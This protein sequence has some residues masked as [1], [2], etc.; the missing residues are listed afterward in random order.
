MTKPKHGIEVPLSSLSFE[1]LDEVEDKL[2]SNMPLDP[3]AALETIEEAAELFDYEIVVE[4]RALH[5]AGVRITLT[6]ASQ[7]VKGS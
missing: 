5:L 7:L 6:L 3:L 4:L 1:E 2:T